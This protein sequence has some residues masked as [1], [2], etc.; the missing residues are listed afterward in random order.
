LVIWGLSLYPQ[1][2]ENY[3]R[4]SVAGFSFELALLNPFA[5]FFYTIY[6]YSGRIFEDIGTGKVDLSDVIF[7]T[8]GIALTTVHFT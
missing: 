8:H 3:K 6:S 5:Y 2:W 7:A 1:A 4:K